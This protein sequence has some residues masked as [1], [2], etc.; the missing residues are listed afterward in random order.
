MLRDDKGQ[1]HRWHT[2]LRCHIDVEK[3]FQGKGCSTF[4]PGI[5]DD[6]SATGKNQTARTALE[7]HAQSTTLSQLTEFELYHDFLV[8]QRCEHLLRPHRNVIGFLH[9]MSP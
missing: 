8:L 2:A 3:P 1:A 9:L 7:A 5:W 6:S 4:A